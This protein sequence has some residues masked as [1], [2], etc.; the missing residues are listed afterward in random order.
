MVAATGGAL[1]ALD[2]ESRH[3]RMLVE[4]YCDAVA[5]AQTAA[6]IDALAAQDRFVVHEASDHTVLMH[7]GGKIEVV[8]HIEVFSP[9]SAVE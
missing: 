2:V 7:L 8:P 6:I 1:T 4:H 3:D 5:A 9:G